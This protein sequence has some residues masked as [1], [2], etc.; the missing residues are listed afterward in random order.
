MLRAAGRAAYALP[1]VHALDAQS[2]I[3]NE[4]Q[5]GACVARKLLG[6]SRV[7]LDTAVHEPYY[8]FV[9][10]YSCMLCS[11]VACLHALVACGTRSRHYLCSCGRSWPL[12]AAGFLVSG[13]YRLLAAA[14]AASTGGV[15][16][17]AGD[18]STSTAYAVCILFNQSLHA[19]PSTAVLPELAA[20]GP[21]RFVRVRAIPRGARRCLR[22]RLRG[23]ACCAVHLI[24]S[25]LQV[26]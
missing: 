13:C 6:A 22:K 20:T 26:S 10:C 9:K 24:C 23:G 16:L 2:S 21:C 5:G 7:A 8:L 18:L 17:R 1:G 4:L 12:S 11:I 19:L 15:I 14:G 3:S 25:A